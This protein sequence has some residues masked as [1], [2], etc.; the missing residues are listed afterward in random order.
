M[1]NFAHPSQLATEF[2]QFAMKKHKEGKKRAKNFKP[3]Q[4]LIFLMRDWQNNQ[5]FNYGEVGGASYLTTVLAIQENQPESLKNVRNYI[6]NSFEKLDCFLLPHPGETVTTDPEYEGQR[7]GLAP[8]FEEQL[9]RFIEYILKPDRLI[10]KKILNKET[11]SAD[12][13]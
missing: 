3:F 9:Q 4:R 11:T 2:S 1:I 8:E 12:F 6:K 13:A 5:E 7:S 10:A